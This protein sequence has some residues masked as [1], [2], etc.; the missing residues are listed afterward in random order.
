MA[1][2]SGDDEQADRYCH[3]TELGVKKRTAWRTATA[4]A[5]AVGWEAIDRH[6]PIMT[7]QVGR[8]SDWLEGSQPYDEP[9][10]AGPCQRRM[11]AWNGNESNLS[12][13]QTTTPD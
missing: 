12:I 6:V 8:A 7:G 9:R 13:I 3:A 11:D 2:L 4:M 10:H 1:I 5:A